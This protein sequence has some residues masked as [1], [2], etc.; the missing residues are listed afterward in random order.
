MKPL[1]RGPCANLA[2]GEYL[3]L[4]EGQEY[5]YEGGCYQ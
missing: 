5:V 2:L 3:K 1:I 4:L